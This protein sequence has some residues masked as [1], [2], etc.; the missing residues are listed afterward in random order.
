MPFS[1]GSRSG[2]GS[3]NTF[4]S[5]GI[6]SRTEKGATNIPMYGVTSSAPATSGPSGEKRSVPSRPS[7]TP[8]TPR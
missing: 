5:C 3:P 7:R 6:V 4:H 2:N 8:P 1:T